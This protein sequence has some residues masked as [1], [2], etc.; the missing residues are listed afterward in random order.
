VPLVVWR[1]KLHKTDTYGRHI[2]ETL[3]LETG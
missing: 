1:N 2:T 3:R